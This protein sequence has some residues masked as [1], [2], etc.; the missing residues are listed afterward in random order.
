MRPCLYGGGV[1][2]SGYHMTNSKRVKAVRARLQSDFEYFA[3]RCLFIKT[4]P[5]E[6]GQVQIAPF[7]FN[8]AQ[9][10]IHKKIEEQKARVG[11]VRAIILKGRQQGASTYTEGR[12]YWKTTQNRGEKTFIMTHEGR[13]TQNL[14]DMVDRYHTNCPVHV[15]P[16]VGKDNARELVFD[17]LDSSYQVATAGSRG[18]GRSATLTNVH[19]SEV[20]FW[21]AGDSHLAGLFQ[22]VALAKGTEII[23]ESTANGVGD[24]FHKQW[25]M[26]ET[27]A[28]DFIPIFVPWF[29]QSEYRRTL[30]HGFEVSHD[31][32]AVPE[33]ELTEA[34]YQEIYGLDDRQVYWRRMKIAELGGGEDGFYLF[35]QEYPATADE[36]F[37][38]S[39]AGNS[40]IKRKFVAR[41]RKNDVQ[42]TGSLIIGVDPGGEGE[43]GDPT[44]IIRRRGRRLFDPQQFTKLNTMQVAAMVARVI[45]AER[46]LRVFVDMG[47]IG[48]GVCDRL[49]EMPIAQGVVVPVNFGEA[50]LDPETY[51]NRRA[52]MHWLLKEWLEDSGGANIP[53]DDQIQADFLAS[54]IK[55]SDSLQRRQLESK[56]WMRRKGIPSPNLADASALTFALPVATLDS[57]V[58]HPAAPVDHD[59]DPVQDVGGFG[60]GSAMTD[61]DVF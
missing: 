16:A 28:S 49:L 4:K 11:F 47:G 6:N 26:A 1:F 51:V 33:G 32:E 52:E 40:L 10:Y 55:S 43:N 30:P 37:Q 3:P 18:A 25:K 21:E 14:F 53:D 20:A 15:K 57:G 41:A 59:F 31:K 12:F 38:A 2:I 35:Q 48:K 27:G 56:E 61:F 24:V 13:A 39:A 9:K 58:P 44:A 19:G 7:K 8:A 23:L 42:S 60:Q 34:E 54:V 36:A 29:W 22:A 50:A 5:D 45:K 17:R 46:P